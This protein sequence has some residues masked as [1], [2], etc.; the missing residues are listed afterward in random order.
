MVQFQSP[1]KE[2][3]SIRMRLNSTGDVVD[4]AGPRSIRLDAL[5]E[6]VDLRH[7]PVEVRV[8]GETA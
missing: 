6:G 3:G 4:A 8:E 1:W 7:H 5:H 2:P